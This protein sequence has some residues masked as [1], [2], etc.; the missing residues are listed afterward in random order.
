M[1]DRQLALFILIVTG[2]CGFGHQT[3]LRGA[4]GNAQRKGR[5]GSRGANGDDQGDQPKETAHRRSV[6]PAASS[7]RKRTASVEVISACVS[8]WSAELSTWWI[9]GDRGIAKR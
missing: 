3:T 7:F 9:T 5:G 2:V 4:R 6:Y 8:A 1:T